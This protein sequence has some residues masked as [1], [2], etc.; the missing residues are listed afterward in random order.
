MFDFL[1]DIMIPHS[2]AGPT[3]KIAAESLG[4]LVGQ[5]EAG[6]AFW[7]PKPEPAIY[8]AALDL[9]GCLDADHTQ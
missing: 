9:D 4:C 6:L 5:N 3:L 7:V 2:Y 1:P 8:A